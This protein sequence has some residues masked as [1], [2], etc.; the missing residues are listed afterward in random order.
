[1]SAMRVL[2]WRSAC[3]LVSAFVIEIPGAEC[4][5]AV[6]GTGRSGCVRGLQDQWV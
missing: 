3:D 5:T 6:G 2:C 1:M 4:R